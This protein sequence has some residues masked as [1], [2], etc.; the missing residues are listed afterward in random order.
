[1]QLNKD[2]GKKNQTGMTFIGMVIVIGAI[3]SI[4]TVAMKVTPAYLEYTA[5]KNAIK[6]AVTDGEGKKGI[7]DSFNKIASVD[8]IKNVSG[9]DLVVSDNEASVDYQ[10]VVPIVA[11]ASI[12]LDFSASATK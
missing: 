2:T 4:A 8:D 11:N 9:A 7:V 12:L 1:M 5:V 6:K 10:V 3:V